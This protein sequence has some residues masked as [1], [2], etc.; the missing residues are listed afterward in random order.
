M[1]LGRAMDVLT[2]AVTAGEL[3]KSCCILGCP[4]NTPFLNFAS[5]VESLVR[6]GVQRPQKISAL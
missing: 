5:S 4:K 6:M 1:R 2:I 3:K